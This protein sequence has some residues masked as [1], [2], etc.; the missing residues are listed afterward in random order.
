MF[1][2]LGIFTPTNTKYCDTSQEQRWPQAV[3]NEWSKINAVSVF[4][5][6]VWQNKILT[7][8]KEVYVQVISLE[9]KPTKHGEYQ[10]RLSCNAM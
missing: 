10:Y 4:V 5:L 1:L 8:C 3:R 6:A 7:C 2:H 9:T